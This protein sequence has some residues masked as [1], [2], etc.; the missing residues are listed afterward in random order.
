M[1]LQDS[2]TDRGF[3]LSTKLVDRA[4]EHVLELLQEHLSPKFVFHN[5]RYTVQAVHAV[6]LISKAEEIT[7]QDQFSLK[8]AA[9]FNH[10]GFIHT[11]DNHREVS[12]ELATDFLKRFAVDADVIDQVSSIVLQSAT[13]WDVV[14]LLDM[15]LYDADF[16]FLAASNFK[17]MLDRRK[18]EMI[19]IDGGVTDLEWKDL[20]D[21]CFVQHQYLTNYGQDF[22]HNLRRVNY[23]NY[24]NTHQSQIHHKEIFEPKSNY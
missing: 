15:V 3:S 5:Q 13:A 19:Q 6:S 20:I 16:Y 8:M 12:A 10:V 1:I 18:D 24:K 11:I 17:E 4:S 14:S 21:E 23:L 2:T 7:L 22:L 9:W